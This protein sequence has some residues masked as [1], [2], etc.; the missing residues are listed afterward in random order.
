MEGVRGARTRRELRGAEGGLLGVEVEVDSPGGGI[1]TMSWACQ[2]GER[3]RGCEVVRGAAGA[4]GSQRQERRERRERRERAE[5]AALASGAEG[6]CG[7]SGGSGGS[8]HQKR[9]L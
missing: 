8:T 1:C 2:S 7:G 6:A 4:R 5:G 9:E 3:G